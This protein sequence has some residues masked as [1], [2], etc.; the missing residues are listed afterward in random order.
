MNE[1]NQSQIIDTEV[2]EENENNTEKVERVPIILKLSGGREVELSMNKDAVIKNVN[3]IQRDANALINILQEVIFAND[4]NDKNIQNHA[5]NSATQYLVNT[6]IP[7]ADYFH[8]DFDNFRLAVTMVMDAF[9]ACNTIIFEA[10]KTDKTT[11]A[12]E[13]ID[14][15]A[16]IM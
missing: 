4:E 14:D 9:V 8:T 2:V 1:V 3:G 12:S 15:V 13:E 16:E 5:I 7:V 6:G 10:T 11:D